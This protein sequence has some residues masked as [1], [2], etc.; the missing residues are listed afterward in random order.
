M[1]RR[2][3][4][5][6]IW[7]EIR[8]WFRT[9]VPGVILWAYVF[10]VVVCVPLVL[11]S[12][13]VLGD[14]NAWLVFVTAPWCLRAIILDKPDESLPK[15]WKVPW[16]RPSCGV[17]ALPRERRWIIALVIFFSYA[18]MM[19][20]FFITLTNKQVSGALDSYLI[21]RLRGPGAFNHF[22]TIALAVLVFSHFASHLG[23][24]ILLAGYVYARRAGL[25]VLRAAH[26]S[27]CP[28]CGYSLHGLEVGHCPECGRPFR[29]AAVREYWQDTY[30][31]WRRIHV[32]TLRKKARKS[33]AARARV[34]STSPKRQRDSQL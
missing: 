3:E 16:W 21:A 19:P 24:N 30:R 20:A 14:Y 28:S 32:K 4:A 6:M 5:I 22:A 2:Q 8:R 9:C 17:Y 23:I 27:L 34:A 12:P 10:Q 15:Q 29:I 1:T 33:R 7:N 18:W 26:F 25:R 31:V 13:D 11:L